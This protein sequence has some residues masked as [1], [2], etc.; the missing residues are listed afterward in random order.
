V[1]DKA[2]REGAD[3]AAR[4]LRQMIRM[5]PKRSWT[6]PVVAVSAATSTGI[7]ELWE[8]IGEHRAS[9][10]AT[11]E[12]ERRRRARML[13]EV[14]SLAIETLRGRVRDA[15]DRNETLVR[16]LAERRIDPYRAAELAAGPAFGEK[17]DR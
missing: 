9:L 2:D 15:L 14:E 1:V 4:D 13:Q 17:M 16:D 11:G 6:P 3:V 7:D 8:A 10:E 12:L 5:G